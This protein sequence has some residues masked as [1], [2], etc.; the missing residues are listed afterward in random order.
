MLLI[1]A[2][3]IIM[4]F[5]GVAW[6]IGRLIRW[7]L[8]RKLKKLGESMMAQQ[9]MQQA[10]VSTPEDGLALV[11]CHKCGVYIQREQAV[12]NAKHGYCCKDH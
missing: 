11:P 12:S 2:I 9:T 1:R 10:P 6:V 4:I 5:V 3:L 8:M 7:A